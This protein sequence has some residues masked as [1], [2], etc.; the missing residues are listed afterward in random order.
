[1]IGTVGRDS[2]VVSSP[3]SQFAGPEFDARQR[4]H[5]EPAILSGSAN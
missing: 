4:V 3:D 1:M 5:A 2:E